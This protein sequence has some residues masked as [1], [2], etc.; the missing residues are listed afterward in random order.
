[1]QFDTPKVAL[2]KAILLLSPSLS[3]E[4]AYQK[5]LSHLLEYFKTTE[6][7]DHQA[8]S[9]K[10]PDELL[11]SYNKSMLF[12]LPPLKEKDQYI[13]E[14]EKVARQLR[15]LYLRE[16]LKV[17]SEELV[18]KEKDGLEDAQLQPLKE[19]YATLLTLLKRVN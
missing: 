11:H 10:L 15:D 4:K 8:F 19:E 14:V 13:H 12:P 5:I 6:D 3:K 7:F 17:V 1:V 18:T 2:D 16:R 9:Q